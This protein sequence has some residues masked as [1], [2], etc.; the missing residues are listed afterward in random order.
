MGSTRRLASLAVAGIFLV[1]AAAACGG[2]GATSPKATGA[3]TV[4]PAAF[5]PGPDTGWSNSGITVDPAKLGCP[6]P[7]GPQSRGVTDTEIKVGGL[8]TQTSSSG[9]VN[10]GMDVGAKIR[11]E[12]ANAEGGVNG[13]TITYVG[14]RDDGSDPTR[15]ITQAESLANDGVFAAV[16]AVARAGNFSDVFCKT[17]TP[18]FGWG[19]SA[20]YCGT[21]LGFGITGCLVSGPGGSTIPSAWGMAARAILGG[22]GS[23]RSAAV[24]GVD[25][26]SAV[27][28]V[29][30]SAK[31]I[32][33]SGIAVPYVENPVPASGL[34]DPTAIVNAL[35]HANH[36]APPD[37]VVTI[38]DFSPAIKIID[39]LRAAGYQGK[40]L[41]PLGYDPRLAGFKDLDGTYTLLQWAPAESGSAADDQMRADFAKY[42]P[43]E[44]IGLTAMAGYW[45]ADMFLDAV[46]KTGRD[47][48][49]ASLLKTLNGGGY[50]YN[51]AGAVAQTQWPVNHTASAPCAAVVQLSGGKYLPT[52]KLS[53]TPLVANQ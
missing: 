50:S 31:A 36:G 9:P 12:R 6:N 8:I 47:L 42:A 44:P 14:T 26:D 46:R 48:T 37:L 13:R 19:V 15:L 16:P 43:S 51:V 7:T 23:G 5:T 27:N 25:L 39:A 3:A 41:T 11:F 29:K 24:V 32:K 49:V 21:A 20:D 53:C 33:A 40:I 30:L 18:F 52:V 4:G 45:S 38:V 35:M 2:S 34:N 28:G 1:T 22:D 17:D 10:T